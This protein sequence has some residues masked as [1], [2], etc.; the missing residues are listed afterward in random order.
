MSRP[1]LILALQHKRAFEPERGLLGIWHKYQV[2]RELTFLNASHRYSQAKKCGY[3]GTVQREGLGGAL[4]SPPSCKNKNKLN[5]KKFNKNNGAKNS[6]PPLNL[7]R[8]PSFFSKTR[9]K[10][11]KMIIVKIRFYSRMFPWGRNYKKIEQTSLLRLD[12][13]IHPRYCKF[14]PAPTLQVS[15]SKG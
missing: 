12:W 4:A 11:I 8:G 2:T 14:F 13:Y 9:G 1:L 15:S 5:K 3:S 6:P 7:L 10:L